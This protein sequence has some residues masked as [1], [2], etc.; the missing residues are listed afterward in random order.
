MALYTE[1][2]SFRQI[3]LGY[4]LYVLEA[5]GGAYFLV[6]DGFIHIL[7]IRNFP[8][9]SVITRAGIAQWYNCELDERGVQVP[10]GAGNFSLHHRVQTGS[11]AY[12]ASYSMGARGS[13]SVGKAAGGRRLRLL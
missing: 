4:I 7:Q 1:L 5:K 9:A 8:I 13:F 3:R 10:S 11:G 12:P 6:Q 2:H